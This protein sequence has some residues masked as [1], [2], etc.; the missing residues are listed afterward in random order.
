MQF[1]RGVGPARALEFEKLGV[2]VIGDLI[3]HFPFRHE[4]KP[5][6]IPIGEAEP[7]EVATIIGEVHSVR[8]GHGPRRPTVTTVVK[9]GSGSCTVSWFNSPHLREAF[10]RGMIVRLTGKVE[11]RSGRAGMTNPTLAVVPEG[12]DAFAQDREAYQPVYPATGSLESRQ[13][14]RIVQGVLPRAVELVD[15]LIPAGLR[16]RRGLPPRRTAILRFHLP[17]RPEDVE[18][19]RRALAYEELFLGQLALL[20][21]RRSMA[22]SVTTQPMTVG[23]ELDRRIRGRFPFK[24]TEG[25]D[26]AVA[27]IVS[28]LARNVP[29]NR[30]LQGDVGCGKTA[31]A[32]YAAL[33][34]VAHRRQVALLAPTE[35]L[36]EQHHAKVSH[37]LAGS[38]V[39]L[40]TLTG[41]TPRRPREAVLRALEGGTIDLI[42]GTHALFEEHA[43]FHDLGLVVID[44]Q[45]KFGVAQRAALREKGTAPHTLVL[46]A[47]PIPRTLAMTLFGDLDVSTIRER[48]GERQD[49]VTRLV[50]SEAEAQAWDFVRRRLSLGE[51]VYVVYP[52]VEES[53]D[54]P[55][56]SAVAEAHRL[57]RDELAGFRVGLL[58][59]R[60]RPA[61]KSEMMESFRKG[62]V[63][64]LV[65]TTVVEVGV[66]VPDA[67]IMAVQHADRFGLS[68]LHQLRGRVGRGTRR[69]YCLLFCADPGETARHR[70]NILVET[71]DGFRIAEEDLRLRGPGELIGRRQH[72]M[73]ALKVA[74]LLRDVELLV[75]A[76]DDAAV[77]LGTDPELCTAENAALRRALRRRYADV[78]PLAGVA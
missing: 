69:G 17:T 19:A 67:T 51:Q 44:E 16:Q 4:H 70:L 42:T 39:R 25:Q 26:R 13:I 46:S 57:E 74:D 59:G 12:E 27:E 56:R 15:E 53:D 71:T 61:E 7:D 40:A 77:L 2:S 36:V 29:M 78:I 22:T 60:M 75:Q 20:M 6:S 23:A 18:V 1:V 72:G 65:C 48:P 76:R 8:H 50:T 30:L 9:D 21:S 52:L 35:I 33:A 31:V 28:D 64:A 38:R 73:P 66:D 68:Q 10:A 14:A 24:L 63:R 11:D 45:H 5:K 37:Y 55:L 62:Q 41:S 47:T 49:V 3:E 43:R 32:V 34:A 58:H 54:L